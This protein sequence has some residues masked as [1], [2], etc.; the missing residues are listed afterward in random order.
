MAEKAA[1]H[2]HSI[3]SVAQAFGVDLKTGLSDEQVKDRQAQHGPNELV[4]QLR[5]GFLSML[6][7]QFKGFVVL[8]LIV[9]AVI[10]LLLGEWIDASA[11]MAIVILNAIL[12]VVQQSKAEEALAALKKMAAP[13]AH[14]LRDG[15]R[16]TIPA[17]ELVPGDIVFLEAGNFVPADVRLVE[18][19]N[20]R[21][22]EAS[23][24]G[25]SVPV[26]KRAAVE[27]PEEIP[28]GDRVNSAFM[29]T[30]VTYG[31]GSGVVT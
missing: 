1:W 9:A 26:E 16:I 28:I 17:R 8:L 13:E 14:V 21:I 5:P 20:L 15:H 24:T 18:S 29:G 12:G 23:L 11:I 4:E 10:S 25:E 22:D 19:V 31:R 2:S 30:T 6:L 7:D 27:L 3:A